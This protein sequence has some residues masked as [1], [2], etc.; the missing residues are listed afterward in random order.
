M[1]AQTVSRIYRHRGFT[2]I[3]LLVVIAIIAILVALLL[4]AVQQVREAARKTQCNDHMHNLVIAVHTYESTHKV[5]PPGA[6][7]YP[8][9]WGPHAHLLPFIEQKNLKDLI[10]PN[11]SPTDPVNDDKTKTTIDVYLCPSDQDAI[12]GSPYG[13][14]SY[15]FNSGSGTI[16]WGNTRTGG[17]GLFYV[18]SRHRFRDMTDG[19]S[20]TAGLGEILLGSGSTTPGPTP[21][22]HVRQQFK[23]TA[24][25]AHPDDAAC[26]SGSGGNFDGFRAN[27]WAIG[28]AGD[29]LYNHSLTPNSKKWDCTNTY[30][31]E[32][33][34]ASRSM[35][36]GGVNLGLMDGKIRFVSENVDLG[37]WR[38]LST[39]D[40]GEVVG[41]Y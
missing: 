37:L 25:S 27:K 30:Y 19:T 28:H 22:S 17:D 26:D 11:K 38:A 15:G 34:M 12:P 7:G 29:T 14:T 8:L 3:E 21:Q 24:S 6:M 1:P 39:R 9:V 32:A 40:K 23:L 41:R 13:P 18:Y 16:N 36:P 20:N 35:H 2:L 10:D 5:F 4:P 31:S 33:R